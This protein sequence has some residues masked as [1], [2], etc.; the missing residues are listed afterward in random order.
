MMQESEPDVLQFSLWEHYLKCVIITSILRRYLPPFMC[1]VFRYTVKFVMPSHL[2]R[3]VVPPEGP[4][5]SFVHIMTSQRQACACDYS[6]ILLH[7][8]QQF[9][10]RRDHPDLLRFGSTEMLFF[11]VLNSGMGL[12]PDL[13]RVFETPWCDIILW[14]HLFKSESV[15]LKSGS[16]VFG[17]A[18]F[19]FWM[20]FSFTS[21]STEPTGPRHLCVS[22]GPVSFKCL[23]APF[24][25]N[26]ETKRIKI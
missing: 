13:T 8:N 12:L 20:S 4:R 11:R 15:V 7:Q 18:W 1:H 16:G 24:K 21:R 23:A 5:R 10:P 2:T 25:W 14:H 9:W 17:P 6:W 19:W 22:R 3:P 26:L